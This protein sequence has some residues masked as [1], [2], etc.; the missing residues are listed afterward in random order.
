MRTH[1]DKSRYMVRK[2]A[3]YFAFDESSNDINTFSNKS[4]LIA[5]FGKHNLEETFNELN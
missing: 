1:T 4:Q 3:P 5:A 2:N